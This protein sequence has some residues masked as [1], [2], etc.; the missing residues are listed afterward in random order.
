M[1][2]AAVLEGL[3]FPLDL[4]GGVSRFRHRRGRLAGGKI[5]VDLVSLARWAGARLAGVFGGAPRVTLSATED[6]VFVGIASAETTIAF[7]LLVAPLGPDLRLLIEAPRGA[8]LP[9]PAQALA[10][11]ALA[12]VSRGSGELVGGALILRDPLGQLA[13]R[14]WPLAGARVPSTEGVALALDSDSK[15]AGRLGWTIH[16]A[17]PERALSPRVL[18]A[19]ERVELSVTADTALV[20]G[21]HEAARRAYLGALDLAPRHPEIARALAELD[22]RVFERPEA[23]LSTLVDAMGVVDAGLLGSEVLE[24]VGEPEA[25]YAA[26]ARAAAE[27]TWGALAARAWLRAAR[28]APVE[29]SRDEAIENALV[30]EPS[31]ETARWMRF[32]ARLVRG[33]LRGA[34]AD[35]DHLELTAEG[36]VSR[37]EVARRAADALRQRG[38]LDAA[39]ARFERSIRWAPRSI[40]ALLGLAR[41]LSEL[42]RSARSLDLLA[43]AATLEVG[44]NDATGEVAIELGKALVQ[45]AQDRS[46]AVARVAVLPPTAAM[47]TEARLLEAEWRAELGDRVGACRALE[48][49]REIAELR[50]GSLSPEAAAG[51]ATELERAANL[52]TEQLGDARAAE[53]CLALSLRISPTSGGRARKLRALVDER[54]QRA[55]TLPRAEPDARVAAP[56]VAPAHPTTTAAEPTRASLA[57][58]AHVASAELSTPEVAHADDE[59]LV[60]Q[61]SQKLRADPNS[62]PV[63]EQLAGVLARLGRDLDLLALVSAR[64][65]EAPVELHPAW[66][67]RRSAVLKRLGETARAEGR[68]DEASLYESLASAD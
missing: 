23:A 40:T 35:A 64:L 55:E 24:A 34:I 1:E 4:G 8:G 56:D 13:R 21:D 50:A 20:A 29:A 25:A 43:R 39:R 38:F 9:E 19:L 18:S 46:A 58:V 60:E 28:L 32:E 12:Q 16:L 2:G 3:R 31:L 47:A 11:R 26:A 49:L 6:G 36:H 68:L 45:V 57:H 66:K 53:H 44:K 51:L 17:E 14:A 63:A 61:L 5:E 27:E 65:D 15:G 48:R 33:D 7:E 41:T 62:E 54:A 52:C 10:V 59:Q 22:L 42:G 37:H 67:L 30:R